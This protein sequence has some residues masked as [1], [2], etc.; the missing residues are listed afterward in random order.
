M[1]IHSVLR[2]KTPVLDIDFDDDMEFEAAVIGHIYRHGSIP[3]HPNG[4]GSHDGEFVYSDGF[5]ENSRTPEEK[6]KYREKA[7]LEKA[8]RA[9]LAAQEARKHKEERASLQRLINSQ[10]TRR[11]TGSIRKNFASFL[12]DQNPFT[13]EALRNSLEPIVKRYS[14]DRIEAICAI[15]EFMDFGW[16]E[17]DR[18]GVTYRKWIANRIKSY[19]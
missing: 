10:I 2:D 4:W 5:P 19:R 9:E 14:R 7:A 16:K 3:L 8:K 11:A 18:M 6:K 12:L 15:N 13:R 1:G 17:A